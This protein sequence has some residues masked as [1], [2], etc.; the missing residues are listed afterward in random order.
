MYLATIASV[1][2]IALMALYVANF[3]IHTRTSIAEI[4]RTSQQQSTLLA[5]L[6]E[7]QRGQRGIILSF[8]LSQND[9]FKQQDVNRLRVIGEKLQKLDDQLQLKLGGVTHNDIDTIHDLAA[10]LADDEANVHD[11]LATLRMFLLL[12][13][14]LDRQLNDYD[15]KRAKDG[16]EQLLL[17]GNLGDELAWCVGIVSALLVVVILPV[18]VLS[19]SRLVHRLNRI[20]RTMHRIA[21]C[22]TAVDVPSTVDVDEVGEL[23]RAVQAFKRNT[24][25][26]QRNSDEML[27]LNGW[28]DLALNNM[29]TGLSI[30]DQN[31]ELVMCNERFREMYNLPKQ[32]TRPG[33]S[34]ARILEHWSSLAGDAA[35][36]HQASEDIE[37]E[38]AIYRAV[39]ADGQESVRIHTLADGRSILVSCRPASDGGWVDVHEDVSDRIQSDRT[40]ERL[41]H[42][43]QLTGLMNRQHFMKAL[44]Q[45]LEDQMVGP[46]DFAVMLLDLSGFM[47]IN[48]DYGHQAGD[49]VL[50]SLAER[51]S[52]ATMGCDSLAR[53]GGDGFG[54]IRSGVGKADAQLCA[55]EL[56]GLLKDPIL[57]EGHSIEVGVTIGAAIAPEDGHTT[58]ELLQRAEIALYHAKTTGAGTFVL[59]DPRL[60]NALRERQGLEKDLKAAFEIGQFELHYQPIIDYKA[61]RVASFEA[62]M[63]WRHPTRGMVPPSVFI[64][65][66]EETGLIVKLGTW[67]IEQA[68]RDAMAWPEQVRVAVNLSAAQFHAGGLNVTVA[69]A[70]RATGLPA[71][72]LEVEV[73]ESLLLTD[74][75]AN[76]QTLKRLQSMGVAIALDDFGTGYASLSYLRSFPFDKLKIDQTF[77]RD[78]PR[79][80][81][82]NAIV[83]SVV[84]LAQML[85][86]RTV[87]EGVETAEHLGHVASTGCDEVQGYFLSRPVP[88]SA[89]LDCIVECETRLY[90]AA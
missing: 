84:S 2:G 25:A 87:A 41:A 32:L 39:V 90:D 74:E 86:M 46:A 22:E 42:T 65:I 72:R 33:T 70:L 56:F 6:K 21:D 9:T 55:D 34:L 66:A 17:L 75:A 53:I 5:E 67:A 80:A 52:G 15:A 77:V 19:V 20:T 49:H 28:F 89:V 64:P 12:S 35:E 79:N 59:F 45:Q 4:E 23:A 31:Q 54:L 7:L 82:C 85:G 73:T 62:L 40:I 29:Q 57:F 27:R 76:R 50:K 18:M 8:L 69:E 48:D 78:L 1:V 47:R 3:A 11:R 14:N 24:I 10:M 51:L 44:T 13:S 63:R 30:F 83:R 60:E 58:A 81:D 37:N 38:I 68:C 43:D 36:G 71:Q 26:L 88:A 61:R 16:H